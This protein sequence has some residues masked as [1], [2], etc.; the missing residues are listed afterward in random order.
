MC[1]CCVTD[2]GKGPKRPRHRQSVS[3]SAVVSVVGSPVNDSADPENDQAGA[4]V[5]VGFLHT[6]MFGL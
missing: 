3:E 6:G 2:R 5:R 4:E 1:T